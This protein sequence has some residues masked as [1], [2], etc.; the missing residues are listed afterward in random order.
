M[1]ICARFSPIGSLDGKWIPLTHLGIGAMLKPIPA[2]VSA[3]STMA[4]AVCEDGDALDPAPPS[5]MIPNHSSPYVPPCIW[6]GHFA[7]RNIATHCFA[8]CRH[9]KSFCGYEIFTD[10]GLA[11]SLVTI[12]AILSMGNE[13]QANCALSFSVSS[14]ASAARASDAKIF[15]SEIYCNASPALSAFLPN[16]I[17]PYTPAAIAKFAAIR[18]VVSYQALSGVEKCHAAYASINRAT[19][20]SHADQFSLSPYRS[21]SSRNSFSVLATGGFPGYYRYRRA[22]GKRRRCLSVLVL[23]ASLIFTSMLFWR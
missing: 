16:R 13:R 11:R 18:K 8:K 19:T 17:S 14:C 21:N 2:S 9:S 3:L 20:I 6:T 5:R 10:A 12:S 23:V 22:R 7:I 4:V 15:S 1:N